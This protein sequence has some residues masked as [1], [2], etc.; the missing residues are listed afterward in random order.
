MLRR[1]QTRLYALLWRP[2][3]RSQ[4]QSRGVYRSRICAYGSYFHPYN[5]CWRN[6]KMHYVAYY[7]VSTRMQKDG[8]GLDAQRDEVHRF[9]CPGDQI[10]SE[11]TEIE[12]GRKDHR[13]QLLS[14]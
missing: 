14:A 2:S 3:D 6:E 1:R 7:R 12:S 4:R 8:W 11:F 9:L 13:S 5:T 10:I